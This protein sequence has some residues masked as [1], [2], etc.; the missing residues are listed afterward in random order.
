MINISICLSDIPAKDRKQ[1]KNGKWYCNLVVGEK[2]ET[3]NY[4]NTHYVAM[5]KTKE[6][7]EANEP[8]VYIGNGKE[9]IKQSEVIENKEVTKSEPLIDDND[10]PF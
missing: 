7:R 10:L 1:G 5:S 6:Q 3:D 9:Y 8:T 2:K 4:G